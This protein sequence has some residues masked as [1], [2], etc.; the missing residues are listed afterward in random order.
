MELL[1]DGFVVL[2]PKDF[3]GVRA[4]IYAKRRAVSD[5]HAPTEADIQDFV[6]AWERATGDRL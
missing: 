6:A 4:L 3:A 2:D 5:I 1:P